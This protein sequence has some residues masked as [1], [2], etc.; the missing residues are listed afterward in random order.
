MKVRPTPK[1]PPPVSDDETLARAVTDGTQANFARRN[2]D[3]PKALSEIHPGSFVQYGTSE[4]S[5]DRYT[6][7]GIDKA[8]ERGEGLAKLRGA[9]RQFHGWATLTRADAMSIGF[10]AKASQEGGHFWHA[11]I[12]LPDDAATDK[13]AH[14]HYAADLVK[15]AKWQERPPQPQAPEQQLT[16]TV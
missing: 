10:D 4:L 11:D 16:A 15:V 13:E 2:R 8:L 3:D 5:V 6:R 14:N 7:M 12:I 9:N 1:I